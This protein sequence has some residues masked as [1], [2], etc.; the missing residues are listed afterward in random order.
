[1]KVLIPIS[2]GINSTYAA[3]RWLSQTSHEVISVYFKESNL[4]DDDI[5]AGEDAGIAVKDWLKANVRDFTWLSP[6]VV[7]PI[8]DERLP[9][10]NGVTI[11]D[12]KGN[13]SLMLNRKNKI[14]TVAKDNS[15]D[16]IVSGYSLENTA[17][18]RMWHIREHS[19]GVIWS[20]KTFFCSTADIE[21][22]IRSIDPFPSRTDTGTFLESLSGRF[23]QYEALPSALRDLVYK[24]NF[25]DDIDICWRRGTW[26]AYEKFSGTGAEF[27]QWMAEKTFAGKWRPDAFDASKVEGEGYFYRNN[28]ITWLKALRDGGYNF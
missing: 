12:S 13:V 25:K 3:W 14:I 28:P 10:R 1:M 22:D 18:D 8:A 7:D 27:D 16:G 21:L 24:G 19:S 9:I 26:D 17:T 4:P 23:E 11:E 2:G 5:Q 6:L 20:G 15:C